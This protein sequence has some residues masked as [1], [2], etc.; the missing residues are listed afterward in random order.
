MLLL[1][2]GSL[3]TSK[4]IFVLNW[5]PYWPKGCKYCPALGVVPPNPYHEPCVAVEPSTGIGPSRE[6]LAEIT[7][8]LGSLPVQSLSRQIASRH[9][10]FSWRGPAGEEPYPPNGFSP[11][12]RNPTGRLTKYIETTAYSWTPSRLGLTKRTCTR[13]LLARSYARH[14][15]LMWDLP[16]SNPTCRTLDNTSDHTRKERG[17]GLQ[18]GSPFQVPGLR[19]NPKLQENILD[20]GTPITK[21]WPAKLLLLVLTR[22]IGVQAITS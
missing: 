17:A 2:L 3:G 10:V 8:T 15:L 19:L 21:S 16:L 11:K 22:T 7:M 5:G 14:P 12:L 6:R 13:S 9:K 1:D 4:W 18:A 20:T